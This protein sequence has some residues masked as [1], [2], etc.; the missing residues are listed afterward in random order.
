MCKG[1]LIKNAISTEV[2]STKNRINRAEVEL[3]PHP[4]GRRPASEHLAS[5]TLKRPE[6]LP[7]SRWRCNASLCFFLCIQITITHCGCSSTSTPASHCH[8]E[9]SITSSV[10][11]YWV[12]FS[13]KHHFCERREATNITISHQ[14]Q[15]KHKNTRLFPFDFSRNLL[16]NRLRASESILCLCI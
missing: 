3:K 16:P 6:G 4:A 15:H 8:P 9:T 10:R 7:D 5:M 12:H 11:T 1:K 14:E 13:C 2:Q